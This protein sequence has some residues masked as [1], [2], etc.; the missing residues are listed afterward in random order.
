[1]DN[2]EEEQREEDETETEPEKGRIGLL[3]RIKED[4]LKN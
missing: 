1:M 3:G 2:K 4:T